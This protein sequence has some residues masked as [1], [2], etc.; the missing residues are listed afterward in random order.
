[1]KKFALVILLIACIIACNEASP[2]ATSADVEEVCILDTLE[3]VDSI[4]ILLGDSNYVLGAI[5]DFTISPYAETIILDRIKGKVSIFDSS[6]EFVNS[7]GRF[8]EAPGEFQGPIAVTALSSGIIVVI[9]RFA[10]VI[11]FDS[12]GNFLSDWTMEGLGGFPINL[13]PFNDSTF[14]SY[15]FSMRRSEEGFSINFLMGRYHALT[16]ELL[17]EYFDWSGSPDPSTDFTPGYIVTASN[18]EGLVYLSRIQSDSWM[19]EVYTE[20]GVAIDT[21]ALFPERQRIAAS[22]SEMI[23]GTVYISYAFNDGE[24]QQTESVNMPEFHPYISQ[25]GV[26]E[27]GNIWCRRGGLP[28]NWWD[29]VTQ[30]GEFVKE[31][32]VSLPDSAYFIEMDVCPQGILAYDMM[33]EDYH[34]LYKMELQ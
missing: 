33:T 3:A 11:S 13:T 8:G 10:K 2:S 26:D 18:G 24:T 32:F 1:M 14:V 30:N 23:P 21:I 6:C 27:A 31:V 5:A 7:F 19:V 4:G 20:N 16:G 34:K 12:S 22:D 9:D 25:L 17:T 29:V 15:S 28:G